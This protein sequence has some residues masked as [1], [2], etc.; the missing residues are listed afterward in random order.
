MP[1][2]VVQMSLNALPREF[3]DHDREVLLRP[4]RRVLSDDSIQIL[5]P[6]QN[7]IRNTS[8]SPLNG[9]MRSPMEA[10][11]DRHPCRVRVRVGVR[12]TSSVLTDSRGSS[13]SRFREICCFR[14]FF[15][16]N[17]KKKPN[18]VL[19]LAFFLASR[20]LLRPRQTWSGVLALTPCI[21]EGL[22]VLWAYLNHSHR[23]T[24][25]F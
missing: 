6:L 20:Y 17:D 8:W 12:N 18:F 22:R 3:R 4:H 19:P 10:D 11:S 16:K 7:L 2:N 24:L 5:E 14:K 21:R 15:S 23:S 25:P 13:S 1:L 9:G